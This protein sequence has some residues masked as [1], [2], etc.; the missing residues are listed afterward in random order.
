MFWQMVRLGMKNSTRA[1]R[2]LALTVISVAI[3][4][5]LLYSSLSA[6]YA[7]Q[8]SANTFLKSATSPL[9]IRVASTRYFEPLSSE[10]RV[11]L[12]TLREVKRVFPR[13]EEHAQLDNVTSNVFVLLVAL[14]PVEEQDVGALVADEGVVDLSRNGCFLTREASRIL[15][16]SVGDRLALH[17]SAGLA[18]FNVTGTGTAVDKGVYMP[19]VFV[20]IQMAWDI[21]RIKY[22]GNATNRV[23]LEVHDLFCADGLATTLT[24]TLGHGYV[25]T[26]LKTYQA[27][28]MATFLEQGRLILMSLVL[29][30]VLVSVFR[31]LSSF[32]SLFDQRR[33]ELGILL[34]FGASRTQIAAVLMSEVMVVGATGAILGCLVGVGLGYVIFTVLTLILR[35]SVIQTPEM[36]SAF[37]VDVA[38]L[39]ASATAGIVLT[40]LAGSIPALRSARAPVV[41]SLRA[42]PL[43]SQPITLIPPRIRQAVVRMVW[44]LVVVALGAVLIQAISDITGMRLILSDLLRVMSVPVFLMAVATLSPRLS[45]VKRLVSLLSH[46]SAQVVRYLSVRNLRANLLVSAVIFNLFAA[47]TTLLML[48]SNVSDVIVA[49]WHGRVEG[50]VN[51]ANIIALIQP[52]KPV[53]VVEDVAA[54][55]HVSA[56]CGVNQVVDNIVSGWRSVLGLVVGVQTTHFGQLSAV[57]LLRSVNI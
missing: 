35:V 5:S 33:F 28:T 22:S 30:A 27:R 43:R 9:D 1:R 19:A 2:T 20:S 3:A 46:G 12:S 6:S 42:S 45:T 15:E 44:C 36:S 49:S 7:L 54:L 14:D 39:A 50:Q 41:E 16:K 53:S 51:A 17:T 26:S 11:Y 31:V 57:S 52:P 56:A 32:A 55:P 34:A 47:S 8:S 37:S 48:S 21:Y 23:Y 40:L 10:V 29:S 13:I 25:A 18:S 4:V 24:Q 38:S